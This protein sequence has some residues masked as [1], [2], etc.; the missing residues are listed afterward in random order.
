MSPRFLVVAGQQTRRRLTPAWPGLGRVAQPTVAER[1][2]FAWRLVAGNHWELARSSGIF[3]TL[4]EV[5]SAIDRLRGN[6]DRARVDLEHAGR[7]WSWRLG[8]DGEWL[9]VASRLFQ[10]KQTCAQSAAACLAAVPVAHQGGLIRQAPPPTERARPAGLGE[11]MVS[12]P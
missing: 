11:T 1:S 8:V 7:L 12:D 10:R 5:G 6:I 4:A 3:G 9:A 2:W